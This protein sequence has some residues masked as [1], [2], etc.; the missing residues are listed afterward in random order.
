MIQNPMDGHEHSLVLRDDEQDV[1]Y[2]SCSP[3]MFGRDVFTAQEDWIIRRDVFD[4]SNFLDEAVRLERSFGESLCIQTRIFLGDF[5][6]AAIPFKV[7]LV[8]D[9][10]SWCPWLQ[11]LSKRFLS[12]ATMD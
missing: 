12:V 10:P 7:Y 11:V 6:V 9:V 8:V 4:S 3:G 2:S 1:F 5:L